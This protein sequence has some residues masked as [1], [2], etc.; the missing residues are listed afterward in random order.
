MQDS[1]II[2]LTILQKVLRRGVFV[3]LVCFRPNFLRRGH[4]I[5]DVLLVPERRTLSIKYCRSTRFLNIVEEMFGAEQL[6]SQNMGGGT[7]PCA[8]LVPT[9][10]MAIETGK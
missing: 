9:A 2:L 5:A 7:Y 3:I 1:L 8:P 4:F 6:V 10:L